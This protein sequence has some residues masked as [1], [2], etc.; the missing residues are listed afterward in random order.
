MIS[1][2]PGLS[3]VR[4]VNV[5][6][7]GGILTPRRH[8]IWVMSRSERC[9]MKKLLLVA[10]IAAAA[11]CGAPALAADMAV[12]APPPAPPVAAPS[13][14][15]FYIGGNVGGIWG[16]SNF[17]GDTS[18]SGGYWSP[19]NAAFASALDIGNAHSSSL[20]GGL[21]AGINWRTGSVVFGIEA[22]IDASNLRAQRNA[23]G[24]NDGGTVL[25]TISQ[26]AESDWLL[27]IRPRVGLI[28]EKALLF[29]TGGLAV[30]NLKNTNAF[31]D[32]YWPVTATSSVSSSLVGWTAGFGIEY[33]VDRYWSWKVEY[34]HTQFPKVGSVGSLSNPSGDTA[35]YNF[36]ADLSSDLIRVGINRHFN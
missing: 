1:L 16:N 31:T 25:N 3:T 7:G 24:L 18:S 36:S 27:T 11:F 10:G 22:D 8:V 19:D 14:T 5:A 29:A 30:A 23:S 35:T 28:Y 13:W 33:P 26:S 20:I 9:V 34:L 21:Q 32:F 2:I 17:R 6:E 4:I 15:G 12:K